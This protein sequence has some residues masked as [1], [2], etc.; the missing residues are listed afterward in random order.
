MSR[1]FIDLSGKQFSKLKVISWE[2]KISLKNKGSVWKCK[3]ECGNTS[4]HRGGDLHSGYSKSCGCLRLTPPN[5]QVDRNMVLKKEYYKRLKNSARKRNLIV[6]ITLEEFCDIGS[7]PCFYC[8]AINSKEIQDR[9]SNET[10]SCNGIDRIDSDL[11]YTLQNC[12]PCCRICNCAKGS[13][14]IDE[15]RLWIER[16]SSNF[17]KKV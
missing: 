12:A 4:F 6:E 15:F 3:C 8:G 7:K 16:I 2:R 1:Q 13:L 14:S 11:G 5:K 10:Y 17:L 9:S